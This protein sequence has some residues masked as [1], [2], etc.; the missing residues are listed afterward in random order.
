MKPTGSEEVVIIAH[1]R[2]RLLLIASI[3]V[4]LFL[5][6][7][8]LAWNHDMDVSKPRMLDLI[9]LRFIASPIMGLFAFLSLR[10]AFGE[11]TKVLLR[12]GDLGIWRRPL[13]GKKEIFIP[14]EDIKSVILEP[15]TVEKHGRMRLPVDKRIKLEL[16]EPQKY[17]R[18]H[19]SNGGVMLGDKELS[20]PLERFIEKC[21]RFEPFASRYRVTKKLH[22]E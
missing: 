4:V 21:F 6:I 16:V 9:A 8:Y 5:W 13:W 17:R 1:S 20:Y 2:F 19:A 11:K 14:W 12:V 22:E 7:S 18:F 3:F 15:A 10:E